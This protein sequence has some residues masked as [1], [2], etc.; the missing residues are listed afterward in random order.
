MSSQ[1]TPRELFYTQ[2]KIVVPVSQVDLWFCMS[3]IAIAI[4]PHIIVIDNLEIEFG[5]G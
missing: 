1:G 3:T 4:R 5:E 2:C